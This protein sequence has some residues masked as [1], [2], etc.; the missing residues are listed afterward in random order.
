MGLFG[1]GSKKEKTASA[2]KDD[3]FSL[4]GQAGASSAKCILAAGIRG[5]EIDMDLS[6]GDT[7]LS[8]GPVS[9]KGESAIITYIDKKGVGASLRPKKARILGEQNYW[10][11]LCCQYLDQGEKINEILTR[12]DN[13]LASNDFVVGQLSLADPVVAGSVLTLKKAGKCPAGLSNVDA[14]LG[15]VEQKIPENMRSNYMSQIS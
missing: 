6:G 4:S 11:D 12:L 14:W 7:S 5:V 3:K 10:M 2:G 13:N 1:F 8:H 15:R 9:A